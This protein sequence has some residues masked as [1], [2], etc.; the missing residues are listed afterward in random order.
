MF[1][2]EVYDADIKAVRRPSTKP[3]SLRSGSCRPRSKSAA[4][5]RW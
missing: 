1:P 5:A 2:H 3:R 4:C